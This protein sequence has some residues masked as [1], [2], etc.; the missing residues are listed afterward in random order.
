MRRQ[1]KKRK[2]LR[3]A[4]LLSARARYCLNRRDEY[5]WF[6][7][8]N[9]APPRLVSRHMPNQGCAQRSQSVR[10]A[11]PHRSPGNP[12][13]ASKRLLRMPAASLRLA[14]GEGRQAE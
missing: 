14:R 7:G 6:E 9:I 4:A 3:F 8:W 12:R 5:A 10:Q 11:V 1:M 13:Y 2:R